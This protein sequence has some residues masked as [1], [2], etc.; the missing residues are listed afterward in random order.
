V[1]FIVANLGTEHR[2]SF[3]NLKYH[4]DLAQQIS[5]L[6]GPKLVLHGVSSV[7][8]NQVKNLFTDG[9]AKAN[10]WT[11]MERDSSP[12]LF[13]E[14]VRNAS[15]IIGKDRTETM[16]ESGLLG[17]NVSRSD[18]A[19]LSH[20]TTVYRQDIVFEEIKKIVLAY[21]RLWYN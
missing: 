2:A 3:A 10:I 9:I 19:S 5:K 20:Y 13:E 6:T 21:L 12:V 7:G 14:M 4:G 16:I 8:N 15:R 17:K 18:N 1:D 11:I